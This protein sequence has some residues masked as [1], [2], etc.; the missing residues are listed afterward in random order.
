VTD[1][2]LRVCFNGSRV[3]ERVQAGGLRDRLRKDKE[4][5]PAKCLAMQFPVG[6]RV[7]ILEFDAET[8]PVALAQQ[9]LYPDNTVGASGRPDPKYV[10]CCGAQLIPMLP[11]T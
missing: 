7:Q 6:T 1:T 10:I 11:S 2:T 4:M 9:F 3:T 5:S 8:G